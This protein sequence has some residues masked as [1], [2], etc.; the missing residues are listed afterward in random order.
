MK[1]KIQCPCVH[2]FFIDYEE[3]I[4][5]DTNSDVIAK[6]MDGSFMNYQCSKCG[7][8]H[9]PEFPLS[10][11]WDAKKTKMEVLPEIERG[12]FYRRKKDPPNVVTIISYPEMAER[13]AVLR[14]DLEPITIEAIKY[15]LFMKADENYPENDISVWYQHKTADEVNGHQ[16]E[17]HLYGIRK[18]EVAVS[19]VP[20]NTYENI[21]KDYKKKPKSEPFK[22]LRHR[23][24]ISLQNILRP[25]GLK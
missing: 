22:S 15:F 23:S 8:N 21:L 4:N 11:I 2:V 5:L 17:F 14:D 3:K 13:I 18:D 9:K 10:I 19:R 25:E 24:Y 6:I 12:A 16:L 7:K 1:Q 20:W